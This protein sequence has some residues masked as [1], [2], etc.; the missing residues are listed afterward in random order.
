MTQV[1]S[2]PQDGGAKASRWG[3]VVVCV[4]SVVACLVYDRVRGGLPDWWRQHGGGIPYVVFWIS[5]LFLFCPRR[6]C[7]LPVSVTATLATSL[8]EFLQLW[9]P[10]WLMQFRATKFGAALLGSGFTWAD[11]PPYFMG[12]AIGYL[13][14]ILVTP[15][16]AQ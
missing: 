4:L 13:L 14:L 7:V 3:A 9:Q 8:L 11:F 12:G 16:A 1:T 2:R 10:H 15:R 6:R 5:F